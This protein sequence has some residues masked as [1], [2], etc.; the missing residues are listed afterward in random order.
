M[1]RRIRKRLGQSL[2]LR[3]AATIA[4][5][6]A[7]VAGAVT[8]VGLEVVENALVGIHSDGCARIARSVA[9]SHRDRPD[10]EFDD[11]LASIAGREPAVVGAAIYEARADGPIWARVAV[12]GDRGVPVMLVDPPTAES[13]QVLRTTDG[14][15]MVTVTRPIGDGGTRAIRIASSLEPT[16]AL[17]AKARQVLLLMCAALVAIGALC[18]DRIGKGWLTP[19]RRLLEAMRDVTNGR[20]GRR[21]EATDRDELGFLARRFNMMARALERHRDEA[22][23]HAAQLERRVRDRTAELERANLSLRT[24]DRAKDAFLSNV[25][26]EMRTPLTSIMASIEI[27]VQYGECEPDARREF[28]EI[29][30]LESRRLLGLIDRVLEIVALEARPMVLDCAMHPVDVLVDRAIAGVEKRAAARSVTILRHTERAGATTFCDAGRIGCVIDGILDN[31]IKFSPRGATIDL[32]V[33]LEDDMVLVK[34]RDEGPGLEPAD[35]ED[36]F[37][38]FVQVGASLTEKPQG[39]GLGLPLARR[40]AE[41]HGGTI[42]CEREPG[43]GATF[44]LVLPL[45]A[46]RIAIGT[47]EPR[48]RTATADQRHALAR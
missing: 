40:I 36:V 39:F 38:K 37:A 43:F 21:L 23:R 11:L 24:L 22:E 6:V 2:R 25:S 45:A 41:A 19:L 20:F 7:G 4:L 8:V 46:Q 14:I 30:D 12:L 28:L 16:R 33:A 32:T 9:D 26:H 42:R 17:Q 47:G 48:S 29:V 1:G 44:V 3:F 15:G 5:L 34:A 31:A 18:G 35:A 10:L 13:R 27:L